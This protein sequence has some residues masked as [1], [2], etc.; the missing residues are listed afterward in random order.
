[1]TELKGNT[2]SKASELEKIMISQEETVGFI[3]NSLQNLTS[4]ISTQKS[5]PRVGKQQSAS[6]YSSPGGEGLKGSQTQTQ[7]FDI[8]ALQPGVTIDNN[9]R[10]EDARDK[11]VMSDDM[12]NVSTNNQVLIEQ[13]GNQ[14]EN[15]LNSSEVLNPHVHRQLLID[16]E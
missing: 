13:Y 3:L 9:V 2:E 10:F 6:L 16:L 4:L 12:R 11:D 8:D 5:S 15:P 7:S 14:N 1:M